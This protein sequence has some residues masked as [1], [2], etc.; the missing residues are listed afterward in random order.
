MAERHFIPAAGH[1]L[2]LPLYDPLT[3]LIGG[4]GERRALIEHAGIQAGDRVLDIGCGTGTLVIRVKRT[5]PGAE[6]VG[7]DPDPKALARAAKKAERA[8]V[9]VQLDRGF[10][11]A[12]AYPDASFDRVLSSF[13]F[14]HLNPDEKAKT[15]ADVR[16]VLAPGGSLHLVDF[17]G[18]KSRSDGFFARVLHRSDD[19][20]DNFAGGIPKLMREAGFPEPREIRNRATLFGRVAHYQADA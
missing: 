11:D 6:V 16:R 15:L 10:S 7:L 3:T 13:M 1:D 17:G 12:L 19:L 8:G 4:D 14:H 20:H 9:S 5:H 2:F 18:A